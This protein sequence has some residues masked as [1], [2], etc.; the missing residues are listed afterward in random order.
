MRRTL[1]AIEQG[2]NSVTS[3]ILFD[4]ICLNFGK[5]KLFVDV[6]LKLRGGKIIGITGANGV[7]KSTLLKL[8]GRIIKPDGGAVTLPINATIAAVSPEMKIYDGLTAVENLKF[9]AKLRGKSLGADEI[10]SLG[11]R[12][13]LDTKTFGDTCAENF[14][15]GMR[16]RLKFMILLSVDADIWLLDEPTANLDDDGR[17]KFFVQMQAAKHDKIILLATNDSAEVDIC[18]EVI[19]LPIG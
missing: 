10:I 14:S 6:T 19:R 3:E 16:Q 5:R 2:K 4:N 7:G 8:A 11:E 15:T 18:D 13:G 12:V 17:Q 9:F 1:D